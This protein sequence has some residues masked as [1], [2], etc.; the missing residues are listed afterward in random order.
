VDNNYLNELK[1][2]YQQFLELIKKNLDLE[3]WGFVQV[4]SSISER[5]TLPFV[6]IN[7]SH[8]CRV[9]FTYDT[10]DYGGVQHNFRET[11]I[12]YSRLHH[13]NTIE[14]NYS[15]KNNVRYEHSIFYYILNFLDGLSPQE[16]LEGKG[17]EPRAIYE[18]ETSGAS[19]VLSNEYEFA[20]VSKVI[21]TLRL[22]NKIW[23]Y[24][25]ES[26]FELFDL[27]NSKLW[28]KY[29]S[30]YNEIQRLQ[31]ETWKEK[32]KKEKPFKQFNNFTPYE[33]L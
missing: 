30:F 7:D 31:Y 29:V 3:K 5:D 23:E 13:K 8:H 32:E 21:K 14:N 27:K 28:E 11:G 24:Y 10:V 17:K 15:H 12:V 33:L 19:W 18:F 1:Q 26:F 9:K 2:E 25:E 16:V 6:I 20:E 4:Y 22:H